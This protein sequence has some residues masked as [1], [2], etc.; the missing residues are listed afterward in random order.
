M[1]RRRGAE[2]DGDAGP[3]KRSARDEDESL[4]IGEVHS[5]RRRGSLGNMGGE[6]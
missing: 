4:S 3:S 1:K 6:P 2:D 5:G